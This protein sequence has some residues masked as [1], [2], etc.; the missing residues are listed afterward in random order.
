MSAPIRF[1]EEMKG[2][3]ALGATDYR[4]GW[5]AGKASST[6]LMF[7]L[8]ISVDDLG[9]FRADPL[10]GAEASGWIRCRALS[11]RN[12]PVTRGVFNLFA[13]GA[14]QGRTTM[15]YRLWFS[16]DAGRP[17]TLVGSRMSATIPDSTC[18]PTPLRSPPRSSTA[19]SKNT[20]IRARRY[21]PAVCWSSVRSTSPSRSRRSEGR[22]PEWPGSPGSS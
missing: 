17:L 15:R 1:T 18:G 14:S 8:T 7:H 13:P 19:M 16:D 2:F 21:V 5:E 20:T 6:S 3:C 4:A 22:R 11:D 9:R 12:L 10:H